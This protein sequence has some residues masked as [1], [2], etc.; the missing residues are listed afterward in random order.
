VRRFNIISAALSLICF[1][2]I[3]A[4]ISDS[5]AALVIPRLTDSI[6]FDGNPFEKAWNTISPFPMIMHSP[7]FGKPVSERT[8]IMV[9]H[10]DKFLWVGARL[11]VSDPSLI[12]V[13]SKK[14]DEFGGQS[15]YFTVL[16]D[17]YD[18]NESAV[19]FM[20]NP[21]GARTDMTINNDAEGDISSPA[22][23]PLNDS[24]NTFWDVLTQVTEEGW[25]VEMRIPL[26]SLRFQDINGKVTMGLIVW[27]WLAK[28][29]ELYSYPP[30]H[31]NWDISFLKPSQAATVILEGIKS[32]RPI[33]ITPYATGGFGQEHVLNDEETAWV[34]KGDPEINAGLDI[35]YGLTSNMTL[36]LTINTDFAQVEADDQMINLTRFSLYFP[37]KRQFFLER[38]NIFD[39]NTGVSNTLFYSRRIGLNEDEIIPII[40]G[41]R[42]TG[43]KGPWDI[44]VM[45]MQTAKS[46]SLPSENFGVVRFKRRSINPYSYFGNIITSRIGIDGSY[47]LVYGFDGLIRVTGDEYLKLKWAQSFETGQNNNPFALN[48]SRYMINWQRRNT[49]GFAYD[50]FFSGY[51]PQF[52]PGIGF[53][54]RED[55]TCAGAILHYGLVAPE[56]SL[57]YK[58]NFYLRNQNFFNISHNKTES[59]TLM[60][61]YGFELKN[62]LFWSVYF[63]YNYEN[64]FEA[65]DL[66]DYTQI[67]VGE[68]KYWSMEGMLMTSMSK[69]LMSLVLVQAGSYF[70]GNRISLGLEPSWAVSSSLRLSAFYQYN[71]V[72]FAERNQKF[73]AHIMRLKILLMFN[74]K[75]SASAFIQY[76]SD[77]H[78]IISNFRLR[79]NPREGNDF[80]IVYNEGTNTNLDREIPTL[81]RMSD[82]TL[83]LK[84]TYTFAFRN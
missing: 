55:Y 74:T 84:Y 35:K 54:S 46:D 82:R 83:L 76:N 12:Q 68:Y 32:S 10:D 47:N 67:P 29:S 75:L 36:D 71:R 59:I 24:W 28:T 15:D 60:P 39:F 16:L 42:L 2:H 26:S 34:R 5:A 48:R 20:T 17:T 45:N 41:A 62:S 7:V 27:R 43:R 8:E 70:D 1:I 25:F 40:G 9:G 58:H 53:E 3:N 66:N 22:S 49:V 18:D 56:A 65:I 80:Y 31:Q 23:M 38:A 51:G 11:Y 14:R 64:V 81:P 73:L 13:T 77:E 33:Y 57:L 50:L 4:E 78:N 63:G 30:I 61:G 37:E 21:S 6:I 19:V 69:P 79:Y 72:N 44:G 52:N